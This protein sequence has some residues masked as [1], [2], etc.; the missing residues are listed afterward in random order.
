MMSCDDVEPRANSVTKHQEKIRD[1]DGEQVYVVWFVR[2]DADVG[3]FTTVEVVEDNE[4]LQ[5]L[6]ADTNELGQLIFAL[7]KAVSDIPPGQEPVRDFGF[8]KVYIEWEDGFATLVVEK[9]GEIDRMLVLDDEE[10]RDLQA[11]IER[12]KGELPE[13]EDGPHV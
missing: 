1:V 5:I 7:Q 2:E 9:M 12:A 8:E 4:T 6:S 11:A 10:A 13:T 3:G